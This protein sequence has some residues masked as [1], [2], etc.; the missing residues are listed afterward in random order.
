[1]DE[2]SIGLFSH[3]RYAC[4]NVV[5]NIVFTVLCMS[6]FELSLDSW[7]FWDCRGA[8]SLIP[9]QRS[10]RPTCKLSSWDDF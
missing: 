5:V 3:V 8:A 1:V 10:P 6:R 9:R 4:M 2:A 7:D